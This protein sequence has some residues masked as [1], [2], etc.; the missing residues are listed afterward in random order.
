MAK[1]HMR[2]TVEVDTYAMA[3]TIGTWLDTKLDKVNLNPNA[4][5]S[6]DGDIIVSDVG[7]FNVN[8]TVQI[9]MNV[10]NTFNR[11][12]LM[13]KIKAKVIESGVLEHLIYA[14]IEKWLCNH[15]EAFP[16][17]CVPEIIYERTF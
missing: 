13:D 3:Q 5:W 12:N 10:N 14:K 4:G 6:G 7:D 1:K 17:P 11:T 9:F 2:I 8:P 16:T 15:D